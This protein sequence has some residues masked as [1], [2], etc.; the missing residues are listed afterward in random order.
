M[1]VCSE[2]YVHIYTCK[3]MHDNDIYICIDVYTIYIE[4]ERGRERYSCV[5]TYAAVVLWGLDDDL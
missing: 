1:C 2:L 3:C 4:R 5:Y